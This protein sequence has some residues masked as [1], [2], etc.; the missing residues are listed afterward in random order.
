ME[1]RIWDNIEQTDGC[2]LWTAAL[3]EGYGVA[4]VGRKTKRAHRLVYE[5]LVGPIPKGLVIDHLC[6]AEDSSCPGGSSCLHRRCVRPAHLEPVTRSENL[7]RMPPHI[8]EA[9]RQGQL[10]ANFLARARKAAGN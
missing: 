8:R 3:D 2:W 1:Q 4:T 7:R 6:H 10:R 5:E 9:Q